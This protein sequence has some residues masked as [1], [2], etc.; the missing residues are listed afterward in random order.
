VAWQGVGHAEIGA[1]DVH[2]GLTQSG[3]VV[4]VLREPFQCVQ[5]AEPDRSL[6][7]PELI[8]RFA[9]QIG[10]PSGGGIP[11]V[12]LGHSLLVGT[13]VR[14]NRFVV[15]GNAF[16]E[17]VGLVFLQEVLFGGALSAHR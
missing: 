11:L 8:Y 9:V 4:G 15:S 16:G 2:D 10:D 14:R 7:R 5:P 17:S 3:V 1:E 6:V 12:G 13:V